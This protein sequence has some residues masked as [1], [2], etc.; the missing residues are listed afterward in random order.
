MQIKLT[1]NTTHDV[2][3]AGASDGYFYA[4]LKDVSD[5]LQAAQEFSHSENVSTIVCDYGDEA[6]ETHVGYTELVTLRKNTI[7]GYITVALWKEG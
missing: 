4:E 2:V 1:N 6:S 7:T 3:W 5:M